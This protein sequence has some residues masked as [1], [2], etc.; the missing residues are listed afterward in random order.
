M[1]TL[2]AGFVKPLPNVDRAESIGD[3][4]FDAEGFYKSCFSEYART[5]QTLTSRGNTCNKPS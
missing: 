1:S 4:L 2:A 3:E 5:T